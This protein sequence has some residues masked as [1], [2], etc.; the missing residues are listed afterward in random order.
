M[1]DDGRTLHLCG[2]VV[3]DRGRTSHANQLNRNSL[4]ACGVCRHDPDRIMVLPHDSRGRPLHQFGPNQQVQPMVDALIIVLPII[5]LL[6]LLFLPRTPVALQRVA[7]ALLVV[8]GLD[9]ILRVQPGNRAQA[10]RNS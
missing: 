2:E 10:F 5:L 1:V 8:L 9:G 3:S 7:S 6:D 4:A